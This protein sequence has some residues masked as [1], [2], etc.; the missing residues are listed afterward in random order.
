MAARWRHPLWHE[1]LLTYLLLFL[2]FSWPMWLAQGYVYWHAR[3]ANPAVC[4]FRGASGAGC[5]RTVAAV[6][7][8]LSPRPFILAALYQPEPAA[9]VPIPKPTRIYGILSV[10]CL[11]MLAALL[12]VMPL[13][14]WIAQ[15]FAAF[16]LSSFIF[17][18]SHLLADK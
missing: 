15:Y 2:G 7:P 18:L 1:P 17:G 11:M 8:S 6:S 14:P 12:P 10:L 3:R 16:T 4:W 9:P 5:A 13:D